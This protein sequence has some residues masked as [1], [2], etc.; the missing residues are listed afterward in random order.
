MIGEPDQ[1][2]ARENDPGNLIIAVVEALG[3]MYHLL[4]SG[5]IDPVVADGKSRLS[6]CPLEKG[7]I[8]HRR[9]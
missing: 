8:C 5:R 4:A 6:H 1:I 7:L 2:Q 9:I 3:E